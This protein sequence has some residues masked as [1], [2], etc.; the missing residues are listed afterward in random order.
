MPLSKG[1]LRFKLQRQKPLTC[2]LIYLQVVSSFRGFGPNA[3][4]AC[5]TARHTGERVMTATIAKSAYISAQ[6]LFVRMID[7]TQAEI[8]IGSAL[9]CGKLL[10][11]KPEYSAQAAI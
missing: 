4:S 1:G 6:G 7:E 2:A 11:K 8:R 10:S 5:G 3:A 9:L